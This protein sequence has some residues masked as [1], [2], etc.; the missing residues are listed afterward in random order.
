MAILHSLSPGT[1]WLAITP[2]PFNA[3][4]R[5]PIVEID[6]HCL[7]PNRDELLCYIVLYYISAIISLITSI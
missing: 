2:F 5:R 6:A 1:H 3:D 7:Y 4:S